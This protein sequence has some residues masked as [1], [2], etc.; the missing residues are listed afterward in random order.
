MFQVKVNDQ[1]LE[2]GKAILN[3]GSDFAIKT[4][5]DYS[6]RSTSLGDG[7]TSLTNYVKIDNN[8]FKLINNTDTNKGYDFVAGEITST[9]SIKIDND[10]TAHPKV[11]FGFGEWNSN[12][13]EIASNAPAG[14]PTSVDS[15][16]KEQL[17]NL[18][19]GPCIVEKNTVKWAYS[20]VSENDIDGNPIE[21]TKGP[22]IVKS[23]Y[24]S[25]N[26]EY[27]E[28]GASGT[29]ELY[30]TVVDEYT[31]ANNVYQITS[32]ENQ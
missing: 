30:G 27:I 15:L 19:G 20:P 11:Y 14:C 6:S 22:L 12:Y 13:F 7:L 28:P 16:T 2:Y 8:A 31:L 17:M 32:S 1:A 4:K 21:S 29:I 26:T 18:Y 5:F 10:G 9:P 24:I 23:T 25:Y 3:Y